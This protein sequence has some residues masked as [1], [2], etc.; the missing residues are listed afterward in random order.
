MLSKDEKEKKA[1]L[2]KV[3]LSGTAGVSSPAHEHEGWLIMKSAFSDLKEEVSMEKELE[4]QLTTLLETAERYSEQHTVLTK[5]LAGAEEYLDE[6]PENVKAAAV[7]LYNYLHVI[8]TA[9]EP[10]NDTVAKSEEPAEEK[11]PGLMARIASA[12]AK[13]SATASPEAEVV[14]EAPVEPEASATP[15]EEVLDW[16]SFLSDVKTTIQKK[17]GEEDSTDGAN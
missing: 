2:S 15:T 7:T 10:A 16:D 8:E 9:E 5:A 13:N 4:T 17:L 14:T 6:A 12:L 3:R 11:K 1:F